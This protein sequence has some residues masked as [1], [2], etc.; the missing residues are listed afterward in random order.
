[1]IPYLNY[2]CK[3]L[4]YSTIKFISYQIG[5]YHVPSML[6]R[7]IY[8]SGLSWRAQ[9]HT[10]A[11]AFAITLSLGALR[12]QCSFC[13]TREHLVAFVVAT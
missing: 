12:A 13:I 6:L 1:M 9:R 3:V 11:D 7:I 4:E 10:E 2:S 5:L 8:Q